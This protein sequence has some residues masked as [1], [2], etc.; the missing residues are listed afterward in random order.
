MREIERRAH[1][2]DAPQ[3][4]GQSGIRSVVTQIGGPGELRRALAFE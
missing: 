3:I 2:I 4:D 1:S